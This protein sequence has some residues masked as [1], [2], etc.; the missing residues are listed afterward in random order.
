VQAG[1]VGGLPA[2]AVP[3]RPAA[4]LRALGRLRPRR[5]PFVV[6]LNR[7]FFSDGER[8]IREFERLRDRYTR[9]GYLVEVQVRYHPSPA[10]EGDMGAWTRYVREVVRRLGNDPRVLTF[11]MTNEVNSHTPQTPRTAPTA[12]P[13]RRSYAA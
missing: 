1:Q 12:A 8:G 4:T 9:R 6:R 10:Q 3:E 2:A 13:R 5:G 7:L 11:Q